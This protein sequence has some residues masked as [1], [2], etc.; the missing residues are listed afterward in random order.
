MPNVTIHQKH[1]RGCRMCIDRCPVNVFS[2]DLTAE[3]SA[4]TTQ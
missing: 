4:E 1:C 3:G 2:S